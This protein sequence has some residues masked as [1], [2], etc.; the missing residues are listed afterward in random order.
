MLEKHQIQSPT[1]WQSMVLPSPPA[2]SR[3]LDRGDSAAAPPADSLKVG[4][5]WRAL[6]AAHNTQAKDPRVHATDGQ[7]KARQDGEGVD[8]EFCRLVGEP[9]SGSSQRAPTAPCRER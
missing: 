4:Q 5:R 7:G 3:H 2:I 9:A 1:V 8:V 6:T